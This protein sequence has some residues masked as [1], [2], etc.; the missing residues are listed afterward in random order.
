LWDTVPV[1][2]DY[3]PDSTWTAGKFTVKTLLAEQD[4]LTAQSQK[5]GFGAK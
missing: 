1:N 2:P 3:L 5:A 4:Y